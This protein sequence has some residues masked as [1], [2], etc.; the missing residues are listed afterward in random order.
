MDATH[1]PYRGLRSSV[2]DDAE[3]VIGRAFARPV[4]IARSTLRRVG[5]TRERPSSFTAPRDISSDRQVIVPATDLPV[6]RFVD[7]GVESLLQKYFCFRTPQITSTT[8][9]I[10]SHQEGRFAIVTDV[11]CGMRWTRQRFARDGIAGR[12]LMFP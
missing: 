12:V 9:P 11:G 6:G 2:L 1:H 7:R 5:D 8:P 10:P 3:P 4:G